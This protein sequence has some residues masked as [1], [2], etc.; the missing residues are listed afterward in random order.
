MIPRHKGVNTVAVQVVLA[1]LSLSAQ[2]LTNYLLFFKKAVVSFLGLQSFYREGTALTI[3]IRG[4]IWHLIS[5]LAQSTGGK[6]PQ[7]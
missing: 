6:F 3:E 2:F 1:L 4:Q 7:S 5:L